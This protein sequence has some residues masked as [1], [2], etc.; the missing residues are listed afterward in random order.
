MTLILIAKSSP[1][2]AVQCSRHHCGDEWETRTWNQGQGAMICSME[3]A[4]ADGVVCVVSVTVVEVMILTIV[5]PMKMLH[6]EL[7]TREESETSS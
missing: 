3:D 6:A 7:S 4:A 1:L 2:T 5:M